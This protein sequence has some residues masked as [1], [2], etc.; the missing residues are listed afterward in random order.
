MKYHKWFIPASIRLIF[1]L[2]VLGLTL[3]PGASAIY[4]ADLAK[5]VKA[6]PDI[7]VAL[8]Q[9]TGSADIGADSATPDQPQSSADSS[10]G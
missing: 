4:S 9:T 5:Q 1:I 3:S 2:V 8:S 10:S 7:T 6:N